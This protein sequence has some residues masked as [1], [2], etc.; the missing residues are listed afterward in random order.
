MSKKHHPSPITRA[1]V[2]AKSFPSEHHVLT[3]AQREIP[4]PAV[5]LAA[6]ATPQPSERARLRAATASQEQREA[7]ARREVK[8]IIAAAEKPAPTVREDLHATRR[9]PLDAPMATPTF[10]LPQTPAPM[11]AGSSGMPDPFAQRIWDTISAA[12]VAPASTFWERIRLPVAFTIWSVGCFLL[13]TLYETVTDSRPSLLPAQTGAVFPHGN[14]RA[15][16]PA[17]RRVQHAVRAVSAARQ[18]LS[19]RALLE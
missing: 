17:P 14:R 5:A 7:R 1:N 6:M 12:L 3:S 10:Q 16:L 8:Q 19:G 11:V 18:P 15:V 4:A 13:G 9:R 2:S